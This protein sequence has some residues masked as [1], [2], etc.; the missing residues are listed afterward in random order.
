MEEELNLSSQIIST[1]KIKC[2]HGIEISK[3]L[4]C[5]KCYEEGQKGAS[6]SSV[7]FST[8]K[9]IRE[10]EDEDKEFINN[11]HFILPSMSE[12]I[13]K[14]LLA[15][16]QGRVYAKVESERQSIMK[17]IEEILTREENLPPNHNTGRETIINIR[18]L[19]EEEI[20]KLK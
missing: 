13:W 20:K 12:H 11:L 9:S 19:L 1:E 17:I 15:I 14:L 4:G 10:D 8:E 18:T 5:T 3:Q 6:L 7:N 16:I 2:K